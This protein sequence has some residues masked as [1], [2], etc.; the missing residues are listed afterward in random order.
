MPYNRDGIEWGARTPV[1]SREKRE[2]GIV[3]DVTVPILLALSVS[4]ASAVVW[5]AWLL[6]IRLLEDHIFWL[7]GLIATIALFWTPAVRRLIGRLRGRR[8]THIE[9]DRLCYGSLKVGI[10]LTF[11]GGWFT[12]ALWRVTRELTLWQILV[13]GP[14]IG[15]TAGLVWLAV[16]TAQESFFRSPFVEQSLASLLNQEE[17]PW[18]RQEQNQPKPL[19]LEPRQ[20]RIEWTER[21]NGRTMMR[22]YKDW[23]IDADKTAWLA[24]HVT[25]GGAL[26]IP[27][28]SGRDKPLSRNDV[29][30]VREWLIG[31]GFAEWVD[32][33][34]PAQGVRIRAKGKA[35]FEGLAGDGTG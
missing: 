26:S 17:T 2:A 12:L 16:S 15:V 9:Y 20:V 18:H 7:Y 24:R 13:T 19:E 30:A 33:D 3:N 14:V 25:R 1:E 31:R 27:Q 8:Y 5:D 6:L 23:P 21:V 29:E 11:T 22:N 32:A 10:L 4:I 34:H 35:L 28:C